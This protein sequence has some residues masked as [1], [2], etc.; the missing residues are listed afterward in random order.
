MNFRDTVHC[1]SRVH[2]EICRADAEWRKSLG[3]PDECNDY[4]KKTF[5][6]VVRKKGCVTCEPKTFTYTDNAN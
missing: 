1:K 2:C 5:T 3:A 6:V 4:K